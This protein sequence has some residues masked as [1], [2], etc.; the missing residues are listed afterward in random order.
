MTRRPNSRTVL[1]ALIEAGDDGMITRDIASRFPIEDQRSA[2]SEVNLYLN[3]AFREGRV[4]R[5]GK[6]PTLSPAGRKSRC[7]RWYITDVGVDYMNP[8][9][10]PVV[11]QLPETPNSRR[12]LEMLKEAG[13]EGV[14]GGV[15][16]R[17]FTIDDPHMPSL[18]KKRMSAP[19]QNLQRRLAWTNQILDRFLRHGWVRRGEKEP[20]PFYNNVPV[21]R[22]YITPEGL[23]YLAAGMSAGIRAARI[24]HARRLAEQRMSAN[25]HADD[26]ITQAYVDYDPHTIHKCERKKAI[27]ELR[28]AGCTLDSIGGVF[29]LTRERIRQIINGWK[30]GICNCPRCTDAE[31]FEVGDGATVCD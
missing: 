11:T 9:P 14:I 31:W 25:K 24:E 2:L 21:Y 17:H 4:R 1:A 16:A 6:E 5:G 7:Y 29:G 3:R 13:D 10:L 22:W 20:T 23:E 26:M 19:S 12:V 15:L 18:I 8:K 28:A 30:T 27:M